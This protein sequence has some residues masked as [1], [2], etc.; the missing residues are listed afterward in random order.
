MSGISNI[1]FSNPE[2]D[3]QHPP[4][5][6]LKLIVSPLLFTLKDS[7]S[8]F[9]VQAVFLLEGMHLVATGMAQQ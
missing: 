8:L 1:S 9:W 3:P 6:F 7:Q 4:K 2:F 5:K